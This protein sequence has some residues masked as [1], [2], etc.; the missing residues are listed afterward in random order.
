[1]GY[2]QYSAMGGVDRTKADMLDACGIEPEWSRKAGKNRVHYRL[3]DGSQGFILH[4]TVVASLSADGKKLVL[5]DGGWPSLT[6]RK[7]FSEAVT[8]FG[9]RAI[10]VGGA[11]PLA[12]HRLGYQRNLQPGETYAAWEWGAI[13]FDRTV[14][15]RVTATGYALADKVR[16]VP[17]IRAIVNDG[18]ATFMVTYERSAFRSGSGDRVPASPKR[19][20]AMI[21]RALIIAARGV[22]RV[23]FHREPLYAHS[24]DLAGYSII[25]ASMGRTVHVGCHAF[26][27]ADLRELLAR[28]ERDHPQ[29]ATEAAK[30]ARKLAKLDKIETER[31]EEELREAARRERAARAMAAA[32][33]HGGATA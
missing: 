13:K 17:S 3:A 33:Q 24:E 6:T 2:G 8:A 18:D 10:S 29:H 9:L 15:L 32:R 26:R 7:A 19:A 16:D 25:P 5:N 14:N 21:H 1:M 20:L 12:A 22:G 11:R 28:L 27:V 31:R 4:E 30:A 23:G